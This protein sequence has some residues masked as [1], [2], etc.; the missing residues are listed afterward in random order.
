MHNAGTEW[1]ESLVD[2]IFAPKVT[3]SEV[4]LFGVEIGNGARESLVHIVTKP[5]DRPLS[6]GFRFHSLA[7]LRT[8]LYKFM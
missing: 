5:Q 2:R 1:I 4:C 6:V 8:V 7:W 3:L